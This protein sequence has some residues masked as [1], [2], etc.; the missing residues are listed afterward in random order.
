MAIPELARRVT[1]T[2]ALTLAAMSAGAWWLVGAPA[3]AGVVGGG[4][5]ALVNFRWLARDV[6]QTD[7]LA[8]GGRI[9]RIGRIGLRQLVTFGGLG[10]LIAHGWAHPVAVAVGLAVLPPVLLAQGLLDARAED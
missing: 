5:I 4:A 7:A 2:G 3:A 8:G 1:T 10:L 6:A 9:G